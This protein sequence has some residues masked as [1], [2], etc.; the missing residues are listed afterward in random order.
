MSL[1]RVTNDKGQAVAA[2]DLIPSSVG[3]RDVQLTFLGVGR[4]AEYGRSAKVYI[5]GRIG[6]LNAEVFGLT[7]NERVEVK[8]TGAR[9]WAIGF[10]D[11]YSV[12]VSLDSGHLQRHPN[13]AVEFI[14][15]L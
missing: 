1:Y 5:D 11:P 4:P 7:V 13:S 15:V 14:D 3:G 9:G 12:T 2:G 8:E 10:P 6:W